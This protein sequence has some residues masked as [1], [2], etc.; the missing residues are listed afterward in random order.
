LRGAYFLANVPRQE[1]RSAGA[2]D[3][4]EADKASAVTARRGLLDESVR[5][6]PSSESGSE[7]KPCTTETRYTQ[8]RRLYPRLSDLLA[9]LE[10]YPESQTA[11]AQ[12]WGVPVSDHINRWISDGR[13]QIEWPDE[14]Q[15]KGVS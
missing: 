4:R 2:D 9:C 13:P 5:I 14:N 12:K 1:P 11:W 7:T 8:Y 10:K 6:I 15:G 3:A